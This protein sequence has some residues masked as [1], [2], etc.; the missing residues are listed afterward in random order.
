MARN[1]TKTLSFP[2][3]GIARRASYRKQTRPYATP[4][5][6]NVRGV[7]S[8]ENRERGGSRPGLTK[9]CETNFEGGITAINSVTTIDDGSR[10]YCIVVIAGGNLYVVEGEN[11]SQ[12]GT[13]LQW[14]DGT[15]VLWDNGEEI[16]FNSSV[17]E[18]S[19]VDETGAHQTTERG[20]KLY[21]ADSSLMFYD[22]L[23]G[24]VSDVI[25]SAGVIPTECPLIC[26]Y[27]DRIIMAK[28]NLWY[29][30]R[31]S[32][33]TDW[34]FGA[35][36]EDT[37]RAV[38]GATDFA[39]M[40][41]Q[42]IKAIIPF[43]DQYMIFACENSMWVL[44]EDP[45][46]GSMRCVSNEIGIIAPEAWALSP[47]GLMAFLSNDGIYIGSIGQ[48]PQRF[49]EERLP[50]ELRNV[51]PAAT[52]ITMAYNP[53]ERGFNLFVN[54]SSSW[55]V[56]IANKAIWRDSFNS[57]HFPLAIS[58]TD[59]G[60]LRELV[61][62]GSDG[63]L[64]KFSKESNTDDGIPF[65]STVVIGPFRMSS[66]DVS[67]AMLAEIHGILADNSGTAR[68]FLFSGNSAEE[69]IDKTGTVH[70]AFT[71]GLWTSNRNRVVR[72]R[73]RGAWFAI[74]IEGNSRWSY[75][76]IAVVG[77]QLGRLR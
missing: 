8:I 35:T 37:G 59:D 13:E 58:S 27:R 57:T 72:T 48:S 38:A 40:I 18:S 63:Y 7:G 12:I 32:D 76:A 54:D 24:I 62:G 26:T 25:A 41:G 60:G 34:D 56:D 5:A 51:D 46:T 44:K 6:Y 52:N 64:R 53:V 15:A 30:S 49:S 67:D 70:K 10:V 4:F 3:A 16:I 77:K 19:P 47:D 42:P 17:S 75:E 74:R 45:A 9:F 39:G 71:S 1:V 22:P 66:N 31:T 55:F 65:S 33:P 21:L 11:S 43:R 50:D 29:A 14:P 61:L 23:T 68:W 20:G 2:L 73:S 28:D 36:M 69:C